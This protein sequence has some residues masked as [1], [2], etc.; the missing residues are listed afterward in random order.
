MARD[1]F[2]REL[3]RLEKMEFGALDLASKLFRRCW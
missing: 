1:R 3:R 2:K